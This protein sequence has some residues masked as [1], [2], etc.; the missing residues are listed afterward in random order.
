MSA[1]W[2]AI[3]KL[4]CTPEAVELHALI[5]MHDTIGGR[6]PAPHS[7]LQEA[8]DTRQDDLKH[9]QATAQAFFG[10]QISLTCNGNLLPE[11]QNH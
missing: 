3:H 9:G 4:H 6:G 11:R 5:D 1:Y 7:V 10:Q 8:A 2:N